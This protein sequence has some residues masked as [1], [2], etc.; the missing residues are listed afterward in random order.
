LNEGGWTRSVEAH[1][2]DAYILIDLLKEASIYIGTTWD[3]GE[4]SIVGMAVVH[5]KNWTPP[6]TTFGYTGSSDGGCDGQVS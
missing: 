6:I 2:Y 5:P 3:Y 1:F 4:L